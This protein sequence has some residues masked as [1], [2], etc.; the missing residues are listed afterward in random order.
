MGTETEYDDSQIVQHGEGRNNQSIIIDTGKHAAVV[1]ICAA[2]CG[3]CCGISI[4]AAYTASIAA[5]ETR[6]T[7]Y[8][9]MDPHSRTPEELA[10]WSKFRLEHEEK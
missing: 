9:L 10:A 8:Y 6:L 5:K 2:L 1:A 7:Q 4:W 3:L